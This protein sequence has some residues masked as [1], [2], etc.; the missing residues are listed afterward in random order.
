MKK[1]SFLVFI[2]YILTGNLSANGIADVSF[3][4]V[5]D[6][7]I[8]LPSELVGVFKI[9]YEYSNDI[10]RNFYGWI[11]IYEDNKY[12]WRRDA[13]DWGYVIEENGDY[14]LLLFITTWQQGIQY[15]GRILYQGKDKNNID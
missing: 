3:Y 14:Y 9:V 2:A 6:T 12:W 11:E 7:Q 15:Y 5:P 10:D 8:E 4:P 13:S 1:Y